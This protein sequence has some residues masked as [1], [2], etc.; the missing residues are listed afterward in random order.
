[1]FSCSGL[2]LGSG[3][4]C[5]LYSTLR[6]FLVVCTLGLRHNASGIGRVLFYLFKSLSKLWEAARELSPSP[7]CP[8]HA[9][10]WK[11]RKFGMRK[12][13][14]NVSE[15]CTPGEGDTYQDREDYIT[16]GK[17]SKVPTM[18]IAVPNAAY[19]FEY[20]ELNPELP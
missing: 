3:F 17:R 5:V 2:V 18:L 13:N 8:T 19:P 4:F 7:L 6:A 10:R 11:F 9:F 16:G 1:M 15:L 20:G 14:L 12:S